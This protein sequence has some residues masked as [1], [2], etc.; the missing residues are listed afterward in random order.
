MRG[1]LI[2][3]ALLRTIRPVEGDTAPSHPSWKKLDSQ[4]EH[5]AIK[6]HIKDLTIIWVLMG[7]GVISSW[8]KNEHKLH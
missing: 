1:R 2:L 3:L 6:W 8:Q 7:K 4:S 5:E